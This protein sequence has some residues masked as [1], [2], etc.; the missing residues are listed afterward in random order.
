MK[1]KFIIN[2]ISGKKH[3]GNIVELI[4]NHLDTSKF[5]YDYVFTKKTKDA[6]RLSEEAKKEK[7][8]VIVAVGGDGT[9]NECAQAVTDSNSAIAVLPCGSGNGFALHFKMKSKLISA[10]KQL[11]HCSVREI[12]YCS[13]NNKPFFNVSGVGFDAHIAHLFS[14]TKIRGFSNYIKLVLK[15]CLFYPAQKYSIQYNENEETHNAFIVSWANASQFGNG[16]EI[17]PNAKVDDGLIDICI[18]KSLPRYKIP[19]LLYRLFSGSIHKSKYVKIIKTKE[20]EIQCHDGRS[21]LDGE[22]VDLGQKIIIKNH[23]KKLKVFVPNEE[24]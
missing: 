22:P 12:D 7:Y 2:P 20:A 8:D 15:E 13:A 10:I 3:H 21:H 17:S 1:I 19:I 11:N 5:S 6:T 23:F 9:L 4:D 14:T 24:K 16:A 18:V